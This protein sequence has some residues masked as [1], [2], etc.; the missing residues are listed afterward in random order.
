MNI[1]EVDFNHWCPLCEHSKDDEF[2][3]TSPCYDC[4][5]QGY[6]EDST[7]PILWKEKEANE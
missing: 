1:H 6:N 5:D 3:E 7:K 4:L 2:D